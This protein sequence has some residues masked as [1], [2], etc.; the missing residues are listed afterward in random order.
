MTHR[1]SS[2]VAGRQALFSGSLGR[3]FLLIVVTIAPDTLANDHFE[4]L[5][6]LKVSS[7][8]R[9]LVTENGKPFFWLGDTAWELFHRLNREEAE[10]YLT[11]RAQQ[12]FTVIQAVVLAELDGL[13]APNAYGHLPLDNR[14]PTLPIEEYFKHVDWIVSKANSL[15]LYVGDSGAHLRTFHPRGGQSSSQPFHDADWLDFNMLQSGHSPTSTNY[16]LIEADYTREPFKPCL[17]AGPRRC[18]QIVSPTR[19]QESHS[20]LNRRSRL[21]CLQ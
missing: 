16:S 10:S 14:D 3:I 8:H 13:I 19:K 7:N 18:N 21:S 1:E 5:A 4:S 2:L 6:K 15:G 11:Q 17:G 20:G 12:G 9:Y